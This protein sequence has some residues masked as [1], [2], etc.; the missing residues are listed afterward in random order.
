MSTFDASDD[1]N[2]DN[3]DYGSMHTSHILDVLY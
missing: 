1:I 3:V 2:G